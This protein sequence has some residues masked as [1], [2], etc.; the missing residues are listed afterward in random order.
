MLHVNRKGGR[1]D[2]SHFAATY[3]A[4]GIHIGEYMNTNCAEDQFVNIVKKTTKA[5][6]QI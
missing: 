4:E 6:N 1:R 5:I 2:L 3:K